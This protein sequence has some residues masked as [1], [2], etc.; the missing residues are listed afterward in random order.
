M[1]ICTSSKQ[2]LV[3]PDDVPIRSRASSIV[4]R[5][6]THKTD[7]DDDKESISF[8]DYKRQ[9]RFQ[10]APEGVNRILAE[11]GAHLGGRQKSGLTSGYQTPR[12]T[13][14]G[15]RFGEMREYVD[16][17]EVIMGGYE[18]LGRILRGDMGYAMRCKA[19]EGYGLSDV[20][21]VWWALLIIA[22]FEC[23]YIDSIYGTRQACRSM[24]AA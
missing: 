4:S 22:I 18:G 2:R 12:S 9:N 11:A 14:K 17:K 23:G 16:E 7:D 24:G 15:A 10:M 1:V 20:G 6:D 13:E 19:A 3:S 5:G 8:E 21:C